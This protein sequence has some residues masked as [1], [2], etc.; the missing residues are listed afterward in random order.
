MRY[1][2]S[3][4]YN[5]AWF[6]LAECVSRGEKERALGVYRLLSHSFDDLAFASQLEGDILFS[7]EDAI[8]AIAKYDQAIA[9]YKKSNRLLEAAAVCEHV[10]TMA[11][12]TADYIRVVVDLYKKLRLT[13]RVVT[14]L[15]MLFALA[16]GH[17]D[18]VN[19]RLLLEELD[20]YADAQS[21]VIERQELIF[22]T[23]RD[24]ACD[25]E[26]LRVHIEQVLDGLLALDDQVALQQFL[27]H[28]EAMHPA[29]SEHA[30][31][32]LAQQA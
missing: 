6:K 28:V 21:T 17:D 32:Y 27:A 14:Y 2:P 9:L 16:L 29:A 30:H 4:K 19:A 22:A 13:D 7:F 3:D 24:N 26:P 11:P 5:V 8:G 25:I 10:I 15:Q 18:L 1:L 20:Q 23:L 31:L 12:A